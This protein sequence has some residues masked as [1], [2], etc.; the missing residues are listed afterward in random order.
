MFGPWECEPVRV[1]HLSILEDAVS[2]FI[3]KKTIVMVT[4]VVVT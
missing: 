4:V 2:A 3:K 1:S